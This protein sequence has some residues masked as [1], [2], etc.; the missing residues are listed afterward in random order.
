MT[1]GSA[2]QADEIVSGFGGG[3]QGTLIGVKTRAASGLQGVEDDGADVEMSDAQ[4]PREA[5]MEPASKLRVVLR[6]IDEAIM[7]GKK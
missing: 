2:E 6:S 4:D 5:V 7:N 3:E 1:D